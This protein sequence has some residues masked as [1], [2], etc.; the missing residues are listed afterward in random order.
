ML[1]KKAYAGEFRYL[2][3]ILRLAGKDGRSYVAFP[4]RKFKYTAMLQQL[5][6]LGILENFEEREELLVINLKQTY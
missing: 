2:L 1:I 4:K 5:C 6:E 3:S